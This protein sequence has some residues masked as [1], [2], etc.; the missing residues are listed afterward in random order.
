MNL[1]RETLRRSRRVRS[2]LYI[3]MVCSSKEVVS[4]EGTNS[5]RPLTLNLQ[6]CGLI[7]DRCQYYLLAKILDDL[8]LLTRK[9][10]PSPNRIQEW[11]SYTRGHPLA[12]CHT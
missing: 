4:V 12:S 1:W 6:L 7:M 5:D 3:P 2:R 8:L 10:R 11:S 9:R